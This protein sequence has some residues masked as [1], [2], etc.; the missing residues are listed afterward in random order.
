MY[1]PSILKGPGQTSFIAISGKKFSFQFSTAMSVTMIVVAGLGLL[2]NTFSVFVLA[3]FVFLFCPLSF[4]V[5]FLYSKIFNIQ[6][7]EEIL[8]KKKVFNIRFFQTTQSLS[9]EYFIK[10]SENYCIIK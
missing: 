5:L 9:A 4:A 1:F 8:K 10:C 3:R 2:G 6:I 7:E